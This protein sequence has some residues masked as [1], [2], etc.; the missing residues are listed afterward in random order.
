MTD[1]KI[2]EVTNYYSNI[3]V[4]AIML[5]DTLSEGDTV[6]FKGATT[7]FT[8]KVKSMELD[9]ESIEEGKPGQEIAIKVK[10]RVREG[11]EVFL[12]E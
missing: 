4:C 10:N 2:G 3:S 11:D 9:R 12:L 1:K 7:D 6:H 5:S 8:Q